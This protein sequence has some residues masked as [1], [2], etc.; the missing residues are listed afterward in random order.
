[1]TSCAAS[2]A[3]TGCWAAP[4]TIIS[5]AA[6][7]TIFWTAA[8]D[9]DRV[10][11][12]VSATAGVLVDLNIVGVP[13]ATGQGNDT[14]IGIEHATGTRFNDVL[15]GDG[16]DNWLWGGSDASGV[17]GN[18]IILA[19]GGNDLVEVGA[20]NHLLAGGSGN[21][22]LSLWGNIADIS[23][24]GVTASLALQGTVQD[25]EQGLMFFTGFERIFRVE[26][27]RRLVR[28]R[29]RKCLGRRLW[30]RSAGRR[31]G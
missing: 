27:R 13:Q 2:P 22:S 24:A 25:T 4:G 31:P 14:L 23:A 30:R 11:Y 15:I 28:R 18:D 19:G 29:W 6:R 1:M 21:N 9:R 26:L 10:S 3:T 12:S 17:T 5:T 20:G 16:G 7:A 8:T